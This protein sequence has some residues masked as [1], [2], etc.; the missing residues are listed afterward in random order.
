MREQ[1]KW[2]L[3]APT[4]MLEKQPYYLSLADR[5]PHVTKI[6]FDKLSYFHNSEVFEDNVISNTMCPFWDRIFSGVAINNGLTRHPAAC[7]PNT[8]ES[9]CTKLASVCL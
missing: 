7:C 1:F 8:F 2:H 5:R 3:P 9:N 6:P 4:I